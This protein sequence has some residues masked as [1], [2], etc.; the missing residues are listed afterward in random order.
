MKFL[1]KLL[2]WKDAAV[3]DARRVYAALMAQS[4][5]PIFYG[6][7]R[8]ADDYD[9]RIDVLTLHI[10]AILSNLNKFGDNGER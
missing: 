1:I 4:R 10:A 6:E 2:G 3:T 7:S 9:G 5:Q 8:F